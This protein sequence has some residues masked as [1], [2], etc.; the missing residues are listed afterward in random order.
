MHLPPL[1]SPPGA[2]PCQQ[3]E[4]QLLPHP[5]HPLEFPSLVQPC[6]SGGVTLCEH[7]TGPHPWFFSFSSLLIWAMLD[8]VPFILDQ[9]STIKTRA[10]LMWAAIPDGGTSQHP[11][12]AQFA[13]QLCGCFWH[14]GSLGSCVVSPIPKEMWPFL[15]SGLV[16][17]SARLLR[18]HRKANDLVILSSSL[19]H[20]RA[21]SRNFA[22]AT[23]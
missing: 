15:G 21:H 16:G 11:G 17:G 13:L 2:S 10:G 14:L 20:S 22:R 18:Q 5:L 12:G 3:E 4:F 6:S 1:S 23:D 19:S 7:G 8:L 9:V